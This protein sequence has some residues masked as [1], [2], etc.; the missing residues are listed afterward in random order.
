MSDRSRLVSFLLC[1]SFGMFG[2]HRF[3][4]GKTGTGIVW[5]LTFGVFGLGIIVDLVMILLGRFFDKD[6]KPVQAWA[7]TSDTQGN[8][9]GY[10]V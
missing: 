8:V 6:N 7:R 5:L 9:T 1:A 3:Y 2:A 4:V 10:I